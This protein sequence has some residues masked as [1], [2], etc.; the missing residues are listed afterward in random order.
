VKDESEPAAEGADASA[1]A[2]AAQ[3]DES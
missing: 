3:A 1:A 2:P